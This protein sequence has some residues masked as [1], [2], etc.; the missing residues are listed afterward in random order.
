MKTTL[1][2]QSCQGF[3]SFSGKDSD[4]VVCDQCRTHNKIHAGVTGSAV[5]SGTLV[6]NNTRIKFNQKLKV[7]DEVYRVIGL[8]QLYFKAGYSNYW[9]L[10]PSKNQS[11]YLEES[12]DSYYVFQ[13]L[14]V[15]LNPLLN[16]GHHVG[17]VYSL[18]DYGKMMFT[19]IQKIEFTAEAGELK[20]IGDFSQD[21]FVLE[22]VNMNRHTALLR[23]F[24]FKDKTVFGFVGEKVSY[25]TMTD[26]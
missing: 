11:A 13:P 25:K 8:Q 6:Q 7:K 15:D 4:T 22:A 3:I 18:P 24:I 26:L 10:D 19:A 17:K 20:M 2:C 12:F 14:H 16:P 5:V 9:Y 1:N 23:F 21:G